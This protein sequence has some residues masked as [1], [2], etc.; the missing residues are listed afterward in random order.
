MNHIYE[1]ELFNTNNRKHILPY[2]Y[3]YSG[4]INEQIRELRKIENNLEKRED[5]KKHVILM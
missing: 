1:C 4:N 3:I 5:M 2:D